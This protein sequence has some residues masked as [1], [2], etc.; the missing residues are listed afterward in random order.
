MKN[1]IIRLLYLLSVT[2]PPFSI[3]SKLILWVQLKSQNRINFF[4][5][6]VVWFTVRDIYDAS[7]R[8]SIRFRKLNNIIN[9]I[10]WFGIVTL[11]ILFAIDIDPIV[12][13]KF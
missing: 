6:F 1:D 12:R 3:I 10:F 4:R 2:L 5:S 11:I 9:I 8:R 13:E 7:S